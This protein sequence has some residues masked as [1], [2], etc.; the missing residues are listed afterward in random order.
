MTHERGNESSSP[1]DFFRIEPGTILVCPTTPAWTPLFA[2]ARRLVTDVGGIL[3]HGSNRRP[4]VR[5][6]CGTRDRECQ[7]ADPSRP[8][9][10]CGRR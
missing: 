2:Q 9:H 3:A 4:L 8:E 7:P 6:P 1:S 5:H 10:T